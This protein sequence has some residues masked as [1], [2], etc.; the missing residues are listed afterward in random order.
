MI[1]AIFGLVITV[2][3]VAAVIVMGYL[4]IQMNAEMVWKDDEKE[5]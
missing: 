3:S 1:Q 5:Q 2:G 4:L